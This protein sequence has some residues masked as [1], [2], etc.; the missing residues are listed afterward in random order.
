MEK[1]NEFDYLS[2]THFLSKALFLG[3]GISRI[4]SS[5]KE[6]TIFCLILGTF[7]GVILLYIINNMSF[8]NSSKFKKIIMFIL[9]FIL[10]IIGLVEFINLINSIYLIDTNKFVIV[11]PLLLAIIYTNIQN[12]KVSF[13][14]SSIL[15][16]LCLLILGFSYITLIPEIRFLNYFPL[17]NVSFIKVLKVS[18]EFALYS[19]VPNILLGGIN[20]KF[21]DKN[22]RLIRHY[23]FSNLVLIIYMLITQGILGIDL[24]K[25]FK[26]P[27]YVILKKISLLDFINNI[28][29]LLSFSWLFTINVYLCLCSKIL[30]DISY[31]I[32]KKKWIYPIFLIIILY[33]ITSYFL[34]NLIFLLVTYDIHWIMC[35]V[36]LIAYILLNI[37]TFK[38]K[39][40]K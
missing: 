35:L 33:F 38:L 31:E 4:L 9:I 10:L 6:S 26:Y 29:N 25:L 3:I 5:A 19:V 14:I 23:L 39:K 34:D 37:N 13:K 2:L 36:I 24:I 32:T 27:E 7:F 1:S 40:N 20:Y 30:F 18:F 16:I 8:Y 22:K 15:L 12:I 17:F 21:K 28:E 11:L